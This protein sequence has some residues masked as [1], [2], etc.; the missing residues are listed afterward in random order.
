M[1]WPQVVFAILL[2]WVAANGT[3][4]AARDRSLSSTEAALMV[5]LTIAFVT[6]EALV[7]HAGG[8]W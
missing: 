1:G 7:L 4:R 8:F 5:M 3:M 2:V 6:G